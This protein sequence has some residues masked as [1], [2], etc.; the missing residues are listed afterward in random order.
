MLGQVANLGARYNEWVVSPVDRKLR[1]FCNPILESLTITPWYVVPLVWIPI[2]LYFIVH[3]TRKYI[4]LTEGESIYYLNGNQLST[5]LV[6][7][8]NNR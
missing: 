5:V 1:L 8:W 2:I 3:G 4:Q 6:D 7:E